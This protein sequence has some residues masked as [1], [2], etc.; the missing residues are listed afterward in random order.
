PHLVQGGA[1][2]AAHAEHGIRASRAAMAAAALEVVQAVQ[3]A[4]ARVPAPDVDALDLERAGGGL[5]DQGEGAFE[6]AVVLPH[7]PRQRHQRVVVPPG[8]GTALLRRV[9]LT[10]G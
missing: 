9:K 2:V 1:V 10:A 7:A 3:A 4:A 8:P 5:A 6:R